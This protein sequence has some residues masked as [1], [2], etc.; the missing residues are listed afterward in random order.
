MKKLHI[1]REYRPTSAY[2]IVTERLHRRRIAARW[3][4][5]DLSEE[6]KCQ[7]LEIAQQLLDRFREEV[8]EFL[9]KVVAIVETWIRNFEPELKSQSSE[10][11][12]KS[13]PE[14]EKIQEGPVERET[15]DDFRVRL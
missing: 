6:Q 13:S 12:G 14:T 7:R 9:Q 2:R 1:L 8:N 15:N 4:P 10:W 11:R 3:V 5:H